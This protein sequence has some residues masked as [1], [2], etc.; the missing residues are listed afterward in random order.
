MPVSPGIS[1]DVRFNKNID[2]RDKTQVAGETWCRQMTKG[3]LF[4]V[5]HV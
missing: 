3:N 4:F 1:S 5:S 2:E